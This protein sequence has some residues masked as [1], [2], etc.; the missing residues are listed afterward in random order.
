MTTIA[1]VSMTVEIAGLTA[2][3]PFLGFAS[4]TLLYCILSLSLLA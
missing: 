2:L 3:T 1:P 4:L